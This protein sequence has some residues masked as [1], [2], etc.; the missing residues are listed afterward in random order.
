MAHSPT[1]IGKEWT[2]KVS[3][4]EVPATAYSCL[5]NPP[6][7]SRFPRLS[8]PVPTMR[9]EYD[10]VVVGSGYG[11]G[12]AASRMARA[13]K[14]VAVLEIGEEKW[15]GEYPNCLGDAALEFH[16]SGNAGRDGGRLL[17]LECGKRTGLY[18]LV[19]GEGQNVFVGNG[20]GGTSL[21][22]AN[23]FLPVDERTLQLS[24]WPPEI[25]EHP[26]ALDP[27]MDFLYRQ[28]PTDAELTRG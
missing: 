18:H 12:V 13:G 4:L 19:L 8:R 16:V 1:S 22:N 7:P 14:Q 10:V 3:G 25:R 27:C 17:D 26:G 23:V 15:P 20:L 28:E 6:S 11:A 21:L 24:A 5:S 2:N 9:P